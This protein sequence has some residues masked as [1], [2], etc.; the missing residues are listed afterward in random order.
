MVMEG[1]R[2]TTGSGNGLCTGRTMDETRT[3]PA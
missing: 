2:R 3:V 1:V